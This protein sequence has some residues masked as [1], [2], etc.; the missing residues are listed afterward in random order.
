MTTLRKAAALAMEALEGVAQWVEKRPDTH[1]WG[2][3]Q[4]VEPAIV[5]L[6][7]A[8][9]QQEQ[10]PVA[11]PHRDEPRGCYRVRCQLGR[12]CVEP[13]YT[14]P[15]RREWQGLTEEERRKCTTSPFVVENYLAIE[16]ALKDKNT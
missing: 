10:E 5:A 14:T 13:L 16:Q 3:W 1:P 15:P 7:A 11:C 9:A 12:K 8:L 4:R 6:R 2:A